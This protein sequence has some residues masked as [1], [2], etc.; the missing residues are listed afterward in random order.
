MNKLV[1]IPARGGSKSIPKKNIYPILGKP[2][3][4][5][6]IELVKKTNL[7]NTDIVVSTDDSQIRAIALTY[8]GIYVINR[9][10]ELAGDKA[11]TEDALI[12]AISEME[13]DNKKKYDVVVTLQPT[14]PLRKAETLRKIIETYENNQNKYDALVSLTED[15]T[16]FWRFSNG[17]FSRLYPDAPRRRQ[18]RTPLYKE[19]SAY[20]VTSV[21]S[22]KETHSI[23]GKHVNGFVIDEVEGID[24]NEIN[25]ITIAEVFI[26]KQ[27]L[28]LTGKIG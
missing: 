1:V 6:T 2:L 15:R 27:Q 21:Q 12:H 7:N 4:S 14:S 9:P 28:G 8:P 11:L 19:N 22:L 10:S 25:D 5:Y 24:I 17:K 3:L 26:K 16:D 18:E 23:L 13:K 20:Y